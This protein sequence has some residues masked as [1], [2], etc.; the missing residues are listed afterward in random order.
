MITKKDLLSRL[1]DKISRCNKCTLHCGSSIV[2]FG[3]G[4][5]EAQIIF[6]G[7]AP[8]K[9][10]DETGTPFVGSS[11]RILDKM[12]LNISLSRYD[13]YITNICKCRPPENRDPMPEEILA[14]LPW[15]KKQ[16]EIIEPKLVVTLGRFALNSLLPGT[17]ISDSHGK[18]LKVNV[19]GTKTINILPLHHPAAARINK[20]TRGLFEEDFKK[21][22][23]I[24]AQM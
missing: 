3:S 19:S 8:G 1:S 20:K 11:G 24:L 12:L 4:N 21:I 7:E 18:V 17:K 5:P 14:C 23:R 10:E 13:V 16:I 22:P 6:I 9:M 2:V 15:L